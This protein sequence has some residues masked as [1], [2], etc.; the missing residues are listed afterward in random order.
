MEIWSASVEAECWYLSINQTSRCSH[1]TG[2]SC[3]H[4]NEVL[5]NGILGLH[6]LPE[7]TCLNTGPGDFVSRKPFCWEGTNQAQPDTTGHRDFAESHLTGGPA[8]TNTMMLA[9][10]PDWISADHAFILRRALKWIFH[11]F[12]YSTSTESPLLFRDNTLK[13][14]PAGE[15]GYYTISQ[16]S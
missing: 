2:Y 9:H 1:I 7:A 14:M 6:L 8:A 15:C 5:P 10:S 4:R 13:L 16:L 11:W 3:S 12:P